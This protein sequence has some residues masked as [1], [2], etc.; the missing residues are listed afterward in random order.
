MF[1]NA[2]GS[3]KGCEQ[4]GL[5]VSGDLHIR[6]LAIKEVSCTQTPV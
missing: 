2:F 6:T 4:V 3:P 1:Y 5:A